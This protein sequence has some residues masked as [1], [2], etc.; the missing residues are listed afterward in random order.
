MEADKSKEENAAG[1][2]V[3]ERGGLLCDEQIESESESRGPRKRP[4]CVEEEKEGAVEV[5]AEDGDDVVEQQDDAEKEDEEEEE[6]EDE[7]GRE[8]AD[9][10]ETPP[11]PAYRTVI[12]DSEPVGGG[13]EE[14]CMVSSEEDFC[15]LQV[16]DRETPRETGEFLAQAGV[17]PECQMNFVT[18]CGRVTGFFDA[19][20]REQAEGTF[21]HMPAQYCTQGTSGLYPEE[22][23]KAQQG[24]KRT[25]QTMA[26]PDQQ[27]TEGDMK[28]GQVETSSADTSLMVPSKVLNMTE[29]QPVDL[30]VNPV[31]A[32]RRFTRYANRAKVAYAHYRAAGGGVAPGDCDGLKQDEGADSGL[33]PA[34]PRKKTRTLYTTDQLEELES[35]FQDDHYPDGDKRKEIAAAIGVTPQRIMVWFQNR[36]AKWRKTEKTTLKQE[37]KFTGSSAT[38]TLTTTT[39]AVPQVTNHIHLAAPTAGGGMLAT[40]HSQPIAPRIAMQQSQSQFSGMMLGSSSPSGMALPA[41]CIPGEIGQASLAPPAQLGAPMDYLPSIPSP[42]PLRRASLSLGTSFNPTNHIIPLMLDTPESSCAQPSQDSQSRENLNYSLQSESSGSNT[43]SLCDYSEHVGSSLK[44]DTQQYIHS[45]QGTSQLGSYQ[46]SSYPPQHSSLLASHSLNPGQ[47]P[48]YQRLPYLNTNCPPSASLAPTPPVDS[49]P[50]Y[51]AFGATANNGV[52]TYAAGGRT[53]FQTQGGNQILLQQGVH[54]GITTFQAFP[55]SDIYG[56]TSQ[57]APTLYQRAP[58]QS[59]GREQSLYQQASSLVP[60]QHYIQVQRPSAGPVQNMFQGAQRIV[61]ASSVYQPPRAARTD[62]QPPERPDSQDTAGVKKE[63]D[64]GNN[65][66]DYDPTQHKLPEQV[67]SQ[68]SRGAESDATFECDFSPIHF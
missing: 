68:A 4:S 62:F 51:L 21:S 1:E 20:K 60:G 17:E 3:A 8:M 23:H 53:F 42:P 63:L 39:I 18:M 45:N 49:N 58:Y 36:R 46:M 12:I 50:S 2:F 44:V 66:S 40:V 14:S 29:F 27:H 26:S 38:V 65:K 9:G 7:T 10:V 22:D 19:P 55:W 6:E 43:S 48:Q 24:T 54:G 15:V 30:K 41:H 13:P 64:S 32:T 33:I 47:L 56:Q 5:V 61:S 67:T 52:M 31:Y 57:F 35:L 34:L 11:M 37:K 16:E 28:L 59:L 25:Y